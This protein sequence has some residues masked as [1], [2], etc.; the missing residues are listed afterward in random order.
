MPGFNV[1]VF[2]CSLLAAMSVAAQ[3]AAVEPQQKVVDAAGATVTVEDVERYIRATLPLDETARA[4]VLA[5]PGIYR[6]MV[7][8]LFVIRMV[9][10]EARN[11]PDFDREQARWASRF[12]HQRNLMKEY[13]VTYVRE[14]LKGVDWESS[15]REEYRANPEKYR[16]GASVSAAHILIRTDDRSEEEAL[17][18]LQAVR[19]RLD[20]GESFADLAREYSEDGSAERGGNLGLFQRGKMDRDFERAAFA[21]QNPG[22]VS[23]PVK[24]AF[25]YHL[26]LLQERRPAEKIPFEEV[27]P[28][29]IEQLQTDLSDQVWQDKVVRLRS[30]GKALL[31]EDVLAALRDQHSAAQDSAQ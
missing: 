9:A 21:L 13:R 19:D 31:D 25:G 28:A 17:V 22:D 3:E 2:A 26:I 1:F 30:Q 27:K 12:T 8:N 10:A 23:E 4:A 18:L 16:R 20:E 5:R 29:I 15:A 7:E 11:A 24:T 14:R 6:E